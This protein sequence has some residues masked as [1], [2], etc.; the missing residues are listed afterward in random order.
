MQLLPHS[1]AQLRGNVLTALF[2]WERGE[3]PFLLK[4]TPV[5]FILA[6]V[7]CLPQKSRN[8]DNKTWLPQ[9][10]AL[11]YCRSWFLAL[12][13]FCSVVNYA[14]SRYFVLFYP[15][16]TLLALTTLQRLGQRD[17]RWADYRR[18]GAALVLIVWLLVNGM[19]MQDWLL[20]L[21]YRQRDADRWLATHLPADSVLF[22]AV[23]PGLCMNNRF[24]V[25]NVMEGFCNDG[26]PLERYPR[27]P[28][29]IL[30]LDRNAHN[31]IW[32]ERWW[33]RAY[34]AFVT[35]ERRIHAFPKLLRDFFV[36]GL[37]D[38]SVAAH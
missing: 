25:V 16:M 5:L 20:H 30:M 12:A 26:R 24:R 2:H 28:R 14:P 38:A 19:W 9:R 17:D 4:H 8:V 18:C 7:A 32:R 34:P 27:S 36:I 23:A 13:L 1:F 37:Y 6:V 22:G 10:A 29:Y 21:T 11:L 31:A 33:D 35:P 15:P 3:F